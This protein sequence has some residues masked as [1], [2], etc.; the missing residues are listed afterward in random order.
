MIVTY[1]RSSSYN[2]YDYCQ[3]QYFITYVLGWRSDSGRRAEQGTMVHKV[4]EVLA[5]LKKY[6]Q[7]NPKARILKTVDDV[8][9]E[10]KV[11]TKK[12]Y[13]NE[14]VEE[15]ATRSYEGYKKDS[16][17][18]WQPRHFKEV[19]DG[20][21]LFLN[22]NS[23]KDFDPRYRNVYYTEPHFDIAIEE[24]WAKFEHEING[25]TVTGQLAIKGTIDLVT[26]VDEETIEVIDWKTGRRLNWATME[27]KTYDKL[28][29]DPQLLL[30]FYAM[31][32]LYPDFKYR[33]MS[34]FFSKDTDGKYDPQ[35]FT[36]PFGEEDEPRF[37][38]MLRK[39]VNK[40]RQNTNPQMLDSTH[41]NFKCKTLCHF[42]KNKFDSGDSD[43]MCKTVYN[44][45]RTDGYDKTVAKYTRDGHNIGY[46]EAPG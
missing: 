9:G 21:W 20:C 25:E 35:P 1:I 12:F 6:K 7:E 46:Y 16:P 40:I 45:L 29:N 41:R 8:L 11:G 37:L 38:E 43:N 2:N 34:I 44:S 32:K 15:L 36:M 24:D 13:E 3:M 18:T 28:W 42:C 30:Y 31:S 23:S 4:M 22:H 17:N 5:A 39:Q 33:L 26:Q 27:E 10:V 14:F 19:M